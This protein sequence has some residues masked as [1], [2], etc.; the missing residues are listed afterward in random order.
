[1]LNFQ[2]TG[3]TNEDRAH[4]ALVA[5]EAYARQTRFDPDE[6]KITGQEG[7]QEV[8][9]DLLC[10]ARHLAASYGVDFDELAEN[11]RGAWQEECDEEA[12]GDDDDR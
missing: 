4:W 9:G 1:M 12:E 8:L 11:S 7:L 5:V 6:Q 3:P 10:D 2:G